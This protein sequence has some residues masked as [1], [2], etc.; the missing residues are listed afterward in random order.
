VN[1]A[2]EDLEAC[3][4]GSLMNIPNYKHKSEFKRALGS[5]DLCIEVHQALAEKAVAQQAKLA[6][7]DE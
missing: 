3:C 1:L 5:V 2:V 6:A 4:A 7:R